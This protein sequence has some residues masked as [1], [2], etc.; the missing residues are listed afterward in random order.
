VTA[1]IPKW[2]VW[3]LAAMTLVAVGGGAFA[4]GRSSG[5]EG[6]GAVAAKCSKRMAERATLDSDFDDAIRRSAELQADL[7]DLEPTETPFFTSNPV[8]FEVADLRCADL[9]G[10]GLDEMVVGLSAGAAARVFEWAIFR[11]NERGRWTLAFDREGSVAS[12]IDVKS[13]SVVVRTPTFGLDDPLCCPSGY[14]STRVGYGAGGFRVISP[15]AAPD[16]RLVVVASGQTIRL[17]RLNPRKDSPVQALAAFGTPTGISNYPESACDY[18]WSDLGL[19]LTFANFG[20][21]DPCGPQGRV[22]YIE[23]TG[24]PALQAGWHTERGA[25]VGMGVEKLE[26][27][28]PGA[29]RTGSQLVLVEAPSPLGG[30]GTSPIATA[31]LVDG[32]AQALRFY[33]GAAGE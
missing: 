20:A 24:S 32:S 9:T 33:V 28:Y 15:A 30:G 12:S 10:D 2:L 14:K 21:G 27:L 29:R 23:L 7:S 22:A 31:Y 17:G 13:G 16:E 8:D 4:L 3:S 25:M 19:S 5:D 6:G 26:E 18:G 1:R 11:P